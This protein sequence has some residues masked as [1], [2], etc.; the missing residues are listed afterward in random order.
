MST[1]QILWLVFVAGATLLIASLRRLDKKRKKPLG[2]SHFEELHHGYIGGFVALGILLALT[3]PR[4]WALTLA[5]VGLVLLV[6][7]AIAHLIQSFMRIGWRGLFW[8]AYRWFLNL[9]S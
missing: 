1:I 8:R 3:L 9:I 2:Y 6:E 4:V 7:D 5:I